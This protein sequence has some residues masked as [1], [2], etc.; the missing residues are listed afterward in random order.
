MYTVNHIHLKAS[1]PGRT[2]G[3]YVEVFGAEIV[4]EGEGMGGPRTVRI[5][6]G[7]TRIN[8][9][10]AAVGETL[11]EGAAD[12]HYGLEHFGLETDNIEKSI[13]ELRS[14]DTDI[15]LP[16]T[17][18]PSGN[19]IAYFKGPDNVRIELVQSST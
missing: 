17:Q 2:A 12:S 7:G 13:A 14:R 19:K 9:S 15:L 5:D 6:L 11:P 4:G 1:D 16:I 18:G 3:W 10:S 8:I